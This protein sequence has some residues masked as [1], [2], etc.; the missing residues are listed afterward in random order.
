M[1]Q[2]YILR[3]FRLISISARLSCLPLCPSR[4]AGR[5]IEIRLTGVFLWA[6]RST[7]FDLRKPLEA[8]LSDVRRPK[9]FGDAAE[10]QSCA[11]SIAVQRASRD[12]PNRA[13][14]CRN[15]LERRLLLPT[16]PYFRDVCAPVWAL[17]AA[18]SLPTPLRCLLLT[19][20][21]L[22]RNGREGEGTIAGSHQRGTKSEGTLRRS[23]TRRSS[24]PPRPSVD[25][26]RPPFFHGKPICAFNK[27]PRLR[28]V[29]DDRQRPRSSRAAALATDRQATPWLNAVPKDSGVS[30]AIGH[31]FS[32]YAEEEGRRIPPLPPSLLMQQLNMVF[33]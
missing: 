18:P 3:N 10:R 22:C 14:D 23:T 25:K 26:T 1:L 32:G 30:E 13:N 9:G 33:H 17:S 2:A 29:V 31:S 7:W 4:R 20:W 19:H 12:G 6:V 16:M 15:V 28:Q 8:F 27:L 5:S 21:G 11:Y 24:P